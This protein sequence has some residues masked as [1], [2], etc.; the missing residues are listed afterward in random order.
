MEML[1]L[2]SKEQLSPNKKS[3]LLSKPPRKGG[4]Y[5]NS[6]VNVREGTCELFCSRFWVAA[7]A[8]ESCHKQ[9]T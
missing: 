3:T 9:I 1:N 4:R 2:E 6:A 5:S 8:M 7:L